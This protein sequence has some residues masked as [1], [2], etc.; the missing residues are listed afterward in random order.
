[1]NQLPNSLK[2]AGAR[3]ICGVEAILN[4]RD[5]KRK[6][7]H[8]YD[9]GKEYN[10]AEFEVRMIIGTGLRFEIWSK[11]GIRSREHEEIE[12]QWEGVEERMPQM[13]PSEQGLTIYRW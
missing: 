2:R 4:P 1:V 11:D 13:Q 7:R 5:M 6:N 10:R 9:F 3:E 12:V 8:W